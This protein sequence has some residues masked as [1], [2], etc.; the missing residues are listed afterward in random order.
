[1]DGS[2]FDT[3][4]RGLTTARSRRG[5]V[6]GLLGAV[7]GLPGLTETEAKHHKKHHKKKHRAA[8][9]P[10]PP[11]GSPGSPPSSP[12]PCPHGTAPNWCAITQTCL[13]AC[14]DGRQFD[15][16]GCSCQCASSHGCCIC[17]GG[18]NP[19]CGTTVASDGEC[20]AFCQTH[21]PDGG[22]TLFEV[23]AVGETAACPSPA[24]H[25][26]DRTC[27]NPCGTADVCASDTR[28]CGLGP[29]QGQ[30]FHALGG[31]NAT[32][33]GERTADCDCTNHEFCATK[34][35]PGAFCAVNAGG[36]CTGCATNTFC[37][38]AR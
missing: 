22:G 30:C 37:A 12:N 2:Q 28:V 5:M 8:P 10:S 6:L 17:L 18:S 25:G 21:N 31:T 14:T 3:L 4:L 33:C 23:V 19:F 36:D 38:L 32:W 27:S 35:G 15:P 9:P 16:T 20:T 26:C 29:E 34:Y 7:A 13:S 11:T 1:M 24:A